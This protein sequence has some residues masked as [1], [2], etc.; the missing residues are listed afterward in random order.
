MRYAFMADLHVLTVFASSAIERT[1][2]LM[3]H[4]T[5]CLLHFQPASQ[6]EPFTSSVDTLRWPGNTY[7]WPCHVEKASPRQVW[8]RM[9]YA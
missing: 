7:W 6:E 4:Y 2:I 5:P 3:L 8:E 1:I 9:H